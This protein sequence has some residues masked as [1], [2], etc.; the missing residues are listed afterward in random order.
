MSTVALKSPDFGM[1]TKDGNEL[2]H[3]I[4]IKAKLY[5]KDWPTVYRDLQD[6]AGSEDYAEATDTEVRE[7]VYQYLGFETDFYI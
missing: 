3:I 1:F 6:L 4:C 7:C 2:V 5:D